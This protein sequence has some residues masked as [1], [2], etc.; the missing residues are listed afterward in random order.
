[1]RDPSIVVKEYANG[2]YELTIP[3][4]QGYNTRYRKYKN[5]RTNKIFKQKKIENSLPNQTPEKEGT[6]YRPRR[7]EGGNT[8]G[9]ENET[10]TSRNSPPS[11]YTIIYSDKQN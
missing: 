5:N 4:S 9:S 7:G 1:M 3:P 2:M 8:T 6:T 11:Q 10:Q